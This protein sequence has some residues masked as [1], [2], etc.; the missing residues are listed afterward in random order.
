M[1]ESITLPVFFTNL[2]LKMPGRS[3][4][5]ELTNAV[6]SETLL[7]VL[8]AQ[9]TLSL[10]LRLDDFTTIIQHSTHVAGNTEWPTDSGLMM[11][12]VTRLL[13]VG[14]KFDRVKLPVLESAAA[15]ELLQGMTPRSRSRHRLGGGTASGF[16]GGATSN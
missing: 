15:Q 1:L 16:G 4:F 2:G 14:R 11:S 5:T 3:T 10:R 13:H 7:L 9:R 6:H 12:L 8:D